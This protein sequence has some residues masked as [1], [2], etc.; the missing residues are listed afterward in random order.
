M[1][2]RMKRQVKI[3]LENEMPKNTFEKFSQ[4][5]LIQ[6]ELQTIFT[7]YFEISKTTQIYYYTIDFLYT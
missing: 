5:L 7:A 1:T 3:I 6:Q 2:R 4:I